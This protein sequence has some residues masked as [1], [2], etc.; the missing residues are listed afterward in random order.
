LRVYARR[1]R[2][3]AE[4]FEH[5]LAVPGVIGTILEDELQIR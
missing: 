1:K 3:L 2:D 4:T 5:A